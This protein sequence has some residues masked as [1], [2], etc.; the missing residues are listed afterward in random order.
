[1]PSVLTVTQYAPPSNN[2]TSLS[3]AANQVV[4]SG[5]NSPTSYQCR[6]QAS[7]GGN[8]ANQALTAAFAPCTSPWTVTVPSGIASGTNIIYEVKAVNAAGDSNVVRGFTWYDTR[9][10]TAVP[11][12]T[13]QANSITTAANAANAGAHPNV[14]ASLAVQGYDNAKSVTITFPDGLMGSLASIPQASRCTLTQA[15]A[16]NCPASSLVGTGTGIATTALDGTLNV[17]GGNGTANLYLIDAKPASGTAIPSQYAAGVALEVK[18]VTGPLTGAQ[19][20]INAQGYLQIN[21]AARNIKTVI[22]NIPTQTT[23][24]KKFHIQNVALTIN[25]DTGG[26]SNPLITNPHFCGPFNPARKSPGGV[27]ANNFYGTGTSYEGNTTPEISAPYNVVNCAAVPFNPTLGIAITKPAAGG[28][29]PVNVNL[30]LPFDN[31]TLRTAI[32]KLPPFI[33]PN[34]PAFGAPTDQCSAGAYAGSTTG[35]YIVSPSAFGTAAGAYR[36]FTTAN[37]PP[38]AIIGQATLTSPLLPTPLTADVY[39]SGSS[40]IPAL[41]IYVDPAKYSNLQ[42]IRIGLYSL[43][44]TP[45]VDPLCDPAT[46]ETGDC[47]T[48]IQATISSTP[49]VPVTSVAMRLGGQTGRTLGEDAVVIASPSDPACVNAG[50]PWNATLNSWSSTTNVARSGIL[51][52]TGCNQ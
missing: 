21:D 17:G 46:S 20:D 34:F 45:Q 52:P 37:C 14:S 29:T 4:F 40:P 25:G 23:T 13:P 19:G 47:P 6:S 44:A 18:G 33:A 30:S 7:A 35:S 51:T 11:T 22:D 27:T 10:F 15:Q 32:V 38:Q 9:A 16:G 31:S 48:Q 43:N 3:Q 39:L 1:V 42:G 28:S 24:G 8:D 26:A 2:G 36:E 41:G 49:D 12:V 50:S 5:T